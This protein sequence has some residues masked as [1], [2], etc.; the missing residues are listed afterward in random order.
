M[1][2]MKLRID[3]P[4]ARACAL[5]ALTFAAG[6]SGGARTSA[7]GVPPAPVA[8]AKDAS[9]S[10]ALTTERTART[11]CRASADSAGMSRSARRPP[12][13]GATLRIASSTQAPANAALAQRMRRLQTGTLAIL[14]YATFTPSLTV[15]LAELPSFRI[16]LPGDVPTAERQFANAPSAPRSSS[17]RD[18]LRVRVADRSDPAVSRGWSV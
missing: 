13:A 6:C 14:F 8:A 10:F 17:C 11:R 2:G 7:A 16:E 9:V 4:V 1:A 12:V 5:L 3:R 18:F 15:T